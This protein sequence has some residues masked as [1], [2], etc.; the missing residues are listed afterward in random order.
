[1]HPF[2]TTMITMMMMIM[3]MIIIIII[4]PGSKVLLEKFT[5]PQS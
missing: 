5:V 2:T 3:A 1:V 4:T